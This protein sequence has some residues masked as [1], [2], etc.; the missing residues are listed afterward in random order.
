MK[1]RADFWECLPFAANYPLLTHVAGE[2]SSDLTDVAGKINCD[3]TYVA[4]ADEISSDL[5]DVAGE[6]SS[7]LNILRV[8]LIA[9]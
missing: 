5:T 1:C 3:L 9:S 2:F 8:N 4:D 7:D 6:I